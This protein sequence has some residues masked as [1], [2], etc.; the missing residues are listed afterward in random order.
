[1]KT[2]REFLAWIAAAPAAA[3]VASLERRGPAQRV[4]VLGAGLAGLCS[5]YELQNQG[6]RVTVLEAQ[7]RPGGRVRTVR[8]GFAPGLYGEAGPE[9]IPGAHD[10]TLHYA[11]TFGLTLLPA[12]VAGT[13][14]FY[15]V[16]GR[17]ILP[18]A[19]AVWPFDLTDEERR[20]GYA[21]LQQKYIEAAV[22]QAMAAGFSQQPVR[23]MTRWDARTPGA[24]LRSEGASPGAAELLALGFG[25][26]FGSAASFLLHLLNS[27]Y[28]SLDP[29]RRRQRPSARGLR[30]EGG[31][32][33]WCGRRGGQS[34]RSLGEGRD[35]ARRGHREVAWRPRHLHPSLPR[36]WQSVS[37]RA[38]IS[39]ETARHPRT[40]L[41]PDGQSL[42][43][44]A[45]TFLAQGQLQRQRHYRPA[46]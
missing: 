40:V 3:Q 28:D 7:L 6:H 46:D 21:G 10:L 38:T 35:P 32:P 34:G 26:E 23:V 8:E 20:L 18:N 13:R 44:I 15:H 41:L 22:Q 19:E 42:S 12:R 31:H 11:R 1:M 25:A 43:A 45:H 17:R 30:E 27:Q 24:W 16:R 5:A 29:H 36:D 39:G 2:R 9:T 33:I 37:G 14:A 4:I